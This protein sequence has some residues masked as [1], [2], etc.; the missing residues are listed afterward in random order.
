M[1]GLL[2]RGNELLGNFQFHFF[3]PPLT[4]LAGGGSA[5]LEVIEVN[6]LRQG[7]RVRGTVSEEVESLR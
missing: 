5:F 3:I 4:G 1:T 6:P 2:E 7:L